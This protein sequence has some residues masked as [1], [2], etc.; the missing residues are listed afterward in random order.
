MLLNRHTSLLCRTDNGDAH[1]AV[2]L[3]PYYK[4]HVDKYHEWMQDS[5][6]LQQTASEP[7]SITQEYKMQEDWQTDPN[8]LTFIICRARTTE[9]VPSV[10]ESVEDMIGDVNLFINESENDPTKNVGELSLMI[11]EASERRKGYAQLAIQ[12]FIKYIITHL[13]QDY[14]LCA[15]QA[16]VDYVNQPSCKLFEKLGFTL[17]GHSSVFHSST[18]ELPLDQEIFPLSHSSEILDVHI[19]EH[20]FAV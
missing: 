17:I 18:Y 8:K 7:L 13:K 19:S 14:K 15:L 12:A 3:V 4:E 16:K 1:K 2:W 11:A 10:A 9:T 6:L 20:S 5:W